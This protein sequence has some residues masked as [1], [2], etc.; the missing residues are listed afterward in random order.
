[1]LPICWKALRL[2]DQKGKVDPRAFKTLSG[3]GFKTG[4]MLPRHLE[5]HV[6]LAF[7][8]NLELQ[9][10]EGVHDEI[11]LASAITI[12]LQA[13]KSFLKKLTWDNIS[14]QN[15]QEK[16]QIQ[17]E[18]IELKCFLK[19]CAR[20]EHILKL[21][22]YHHSGNV[23]LVGDAAHAMYFLLGQGVACGLM[24]ASSLGKERKISTALENYSNDTVPEAS[25]I[26]YLNLIS[27]VLEGGLLIK[28]ATLPITLLPA[29]GG[30]VLFQDVVGT[31]KTYQ[32]IL[33][34]NRFLIWIC[35]QVWKKKRFSKPTNNH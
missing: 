3:A 12:A 22:K 29:L 11:E 1:M 32:E 10:P 25:A 18:D 33:K 27:H 17:F 15:T 2:P 26:L 20:Q 7:W 5:G 8:D 34:K 23:A 24:L 19:D 21:N 30:S 35:K 14:K 4:G 6:V 9:N 28:L 13:K 16:L 31:T